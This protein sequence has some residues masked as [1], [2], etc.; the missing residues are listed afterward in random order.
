MLHIVHVHIKY[1]VQVVVCICFSFIQ[2]IVNQTVYLEL[3]LHVTATV[4]TWQL[5]KP[6]LLTV[7]ITFLAYVCSLSTSLDKHL[8]GMLANKL[9]PGKSARSLKTNLQMSRSVGMD[10]ECCGSTTALL[11]IMVW[12]LACSWFVYIVSPTPASSAVSQTN[13]HNYHLSNNMWQHFRYVVFKFPQFNYI[14]IMIKLSWC[15]F[16]SV[17]FFMFINKSIGF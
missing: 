12:T 16:S 7:N 1:S 15:W 8:V 2:H 13:S 6:W 17:V 4:T 5:L 14:F 11:I 9:P 3:Y 10:L